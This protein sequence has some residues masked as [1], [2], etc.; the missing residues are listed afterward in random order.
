MRIG[1]TAARSLSDCLLMRLGATRGCRRRV[2]VSG[3]L[4]VK[5]SLLVIKRE[6]RALLGSVA[7]LRGIS[8]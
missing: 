7:A 6:R 2:R 4:Y 5:G 3:G 1:E 8:L